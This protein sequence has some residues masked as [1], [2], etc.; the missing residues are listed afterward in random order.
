MGLSIEVSA[1]DKAALDRLLIGIKNG[2]PRV[3]SGAI[4]KTLKTTQVQAVKRIGQELNLKAARI[5]SDFSQERATWAVTRG[6]LIAKGAPVG[7][8]NYAANEVKAGVSVKVK[9]TESRTLI[10]GAYAAF[11]GSRAHVYRRQ[12]HATKKAVVPGRKYGAMPKKY[13]L[14]T[15][16]LSGPRIEDIYAKPIIHGQISTLAANKF[17]ENVGRETTTVLRR[18]G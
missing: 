14:P 9:K 12:Y 8:I 10:K 3:L 18:F 16:R 11:R 13:R 5:K 6:A 1:L 7:L 2:V 4:N 15:E 17:A